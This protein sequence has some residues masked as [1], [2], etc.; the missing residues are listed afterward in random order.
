MT[1]VLLPR[2]LQH[3]S[4]GGNLSSIVS[5]EGSGLVTLDVLLLVPWTSPV[6]GLQQQ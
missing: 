6:D 3:P 2:G 4:F 5:A 1:P